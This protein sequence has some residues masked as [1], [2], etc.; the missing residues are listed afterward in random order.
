MNTFKKI[1]AASVVALAGF[2]ASA[3]EITIGGVTW[4]PDYASLTAN[5]FISSGNFT[6]WYVNPPGSAP[7]T[8]DIN[9]VVPGTVGSV[10]QGIGEITTFNGKSA[11]TSPFVCATCELTFSFGGLVFDGDLTD[12]SL[13]DLAASA[14]SGYF[15][16]YFDDSADFDNGNIQGQADANNALDG[17]LFLGLSFKSLQE[18]VGFTPAA[19]SIDSIWDVT[20]GAA[21]YHFDTDTQ[22]LG[23]DVRFGSNVIFQGLYGQSNGLANG[24]TI[25]EPSTLAILGLGLLG[26][27]GAKRRKKA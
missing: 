15:N 20:S 11:A 6:Q 13:F 8:T 12:G 4:D 22:L 7:G 1:V 25:P 17:T 21:A 10:L 19:G 18:G 9:A 5:D 3:D 24:N 16:I 23:S 27:A 26:L 14:V 2:S